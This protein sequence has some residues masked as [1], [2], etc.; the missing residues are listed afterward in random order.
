VPGANKV[1]GDRLDQ[2]ALA[3]LEARNPAQPGAR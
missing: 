3:M 1:A 2:Q